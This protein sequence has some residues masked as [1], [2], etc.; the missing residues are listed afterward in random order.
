M[1]ELKRRFIMMKAENP[2]LG[3]VIIFGM[4][5]KGQVYPKEVIQRAFNSLVSK[6]EY[7]KEE[8]AEIVESLLKYTQK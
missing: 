3:D 8:K 5:V 7:E 1:K 2:F 6:D 4:A